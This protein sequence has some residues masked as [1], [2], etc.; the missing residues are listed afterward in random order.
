MTHKPDKI[1]WFFQGYKDFYYLEK[2]HVA[3]GVY[4]NYIQT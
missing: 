1:I 3:Y 4:Q 2:Y